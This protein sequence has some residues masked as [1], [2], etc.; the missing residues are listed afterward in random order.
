MNK[1]D[2]YLNT[3]FSNQNTLFTAGKNWN[4]ITER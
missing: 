2:H 3:L 1:Q 4:R